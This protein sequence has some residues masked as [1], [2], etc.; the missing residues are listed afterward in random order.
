MSFDEPALNPA[1][2]EVLDRLGRGE[3]PP[4]QYPTDLRDRLLTQLERD[5]APTVEDLPEGERLF[6]SKHVLAQVH[7]CEARYLA[8]EDAGFAW[9]VPLAVGTITHKA[10]ELTLNWRGEQIPNTLV[11]EAM[12]K[13]E[14]DSSGVGEFL[15]TCSAADRAELE[16]AATDRLAKFIECFPPLNP[17]WRPVVESR[18]YAELCDGRVVLQGR[19]DLTLGHAEGTTA[20]KVIIDLKTGR[21][22]PVHRHD[23]YFYALVETLRIGVP[24]RLLATYYL[25]AARVDADPVSEDV[26]RSAAMR[27]AAGATRLVLLTRDPD[28]AVKRPGPPCHWCLLRDDCAEGQAWM[29]GRDELDSRIDDDW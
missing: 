25:D 24:P 14:V 27:V 8:E 23:L 17:R 12:A 6:L 3:G 19:V 7:G 28:V 26:L 13:L 18:I 21:F 20:R 9:S 22:S 15:Q 2:Q 4:P 5:L 11:E 16:G 29:E 1:Q 10:I